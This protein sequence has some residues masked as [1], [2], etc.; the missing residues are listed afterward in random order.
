MRKSK[1]L[2]EIKKKIDDSIRNL[3]IKIKQISI[4]KLKKN[5]NQFEKIIIIM[6]NNCVNYTRFGW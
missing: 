4:E 3:E 2:I 6:L 5:L 1:R